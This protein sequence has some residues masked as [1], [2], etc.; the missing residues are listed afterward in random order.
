[1]SFHS[2]VYDILGERIISFRELVYN[3]LGGVTILISEPRNYDGSVFNE[4]EIAV[5]D[6][7]V[8]N[9]SDYTLKNV[10]VQISVTGCAKIYPFRIWGKSELLGEHGLFDGEESWNILH[11]HDT[12]SFIVRIKGICAGMAYAKA[13]ICAEVVPFASREVSSTLSFPVYED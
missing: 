11:P 7:Q 3:A 6:V 4:K 12:K 13:E 9:G 5:L 10:V 1:M 8:I 2:P